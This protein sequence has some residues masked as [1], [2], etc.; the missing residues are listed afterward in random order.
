MYSFLLSS[1]ENIKRVKGVKRYYVDRLMHSEFK[2]VLLRSSQLF[3]TFNSIRSFK[4][5]VYSFKETK[6][7]LSPFE[8]KR[9][10]CS[11]E[12]HSLAY[13]NYKILLMDAEESSRGI[14]R[15]KGNREEIEVRLDQKKRRGSRL[16]L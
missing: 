9:W 5:N 7:A 3:A 12:V 16:S 8:D 1:G 2:K 6:L 15:K 11:N 10:L 4:H 14:K 13:G